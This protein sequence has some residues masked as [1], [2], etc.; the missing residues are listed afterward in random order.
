[1]EL[2]LAAMLLFAILL[3]GALISAGN[4]RQRRAIDGLREQAERWAEQDIRIKRE[5]LARQIT[6]PEPL[7]WLEKVAA[8]SLGSA[9]KLVTATPWQKDGL[10]ALIGLCQD[11]RRLVFTPIPRD[12]LL[13]ALKMK[14]KG[15]LAEM[16]STLLDDNPKRI[17]WF[18]LSVVTSGMFF[19]IEAGQTWQALTGEPLTTGRLTMYE[20]PALGNGKK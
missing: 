3:L 16:N 1:M 12:R 19:D 11:G 15:A 4:E 8:D 14:G 6:V 20:I 13:K 9:P 5:K 10:T 18:D 7:A 2:L 17:P